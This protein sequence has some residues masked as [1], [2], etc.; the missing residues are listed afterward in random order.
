MNTKNFKHTIGE[1][2]VLQSWSDADYWISDGVLIEKPC[3]HDPMWEYLRLVDELIGSGLLSERCVRT[4][5]DMR[6]DLK[7]LR[8]EFMKVNLG[9]D[10]PEDL[11]AELEELKRPMFSTIEEWEEFFNKQK[12]GER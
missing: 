7:E 2:R 4:L 11:L 1:Y 3:G 10:M 9:G 12:G 5:K 8:L 6:T